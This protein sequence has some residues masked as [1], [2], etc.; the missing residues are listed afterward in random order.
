MKSF[1]IRAGVLALALLIPAATVSGQTAST[2]SV[3]SQQVLVDEY[4]A[5][6]HNDDLRAG[7]FSWTELDLAS[8]GTNA[9]QSEAV[10][11]KLKAGMMPPVGIPRPDAADARAFYRAL[12]LVVDSSAVD[13]PYAGAPELHR[14]NR[15]EYAN[16]VRELLDFDVDVS[17]LLPPDQMS[18]GFDN[19]ADSLSVTPALVQGYVRAASQISRRAVG[20]TEVAPTMSMY[21]VPKVFNQVRHIEGTP[22]GTRGGTSVVYNFPADGE[23]TFKVTFYH[24]FIT[25]LFGRNLPQNLQG[26]E[27]EI[28]IDGA[29]LAIFEI[30]PA[31]GE[32]EN[33]LTTER[34]SVTAGEH[35]I[36]AAFIKKFDGPTED[37]FRQVEQTM[38]DVTAAVPGLIG[39][40]HLHTLTIAGPFVVTGMSETP[41]RLRIFSCTPSSSAEELPCAEQIVSTLARHAYRRPITDD[42]VE[43]LI[44]HYRAGREEGDFED[45]IQMAVQAVLSHPEFVFR[46]EKV[47][48]NVRPGTNYRISDLELASRLAFFLWSSLPDDRLLR[49]ASEERLRDPAILEQEVGRMLADDRATA[50]ADN[51]AYQWLRLQTVKEADPESLVFP[52]FTRNLG[53]SMTRETKMLFESILREDRNITDLLTADYTFVDEIL[54]KHYGIPDVLGNRFRRVSLTDSNRFGLLGHGSVLTLTSL[55]NRTSP[56]MRGKY[57]MEV[58]I[59]SPPPPPPPVVPP[60]EEAVDNQVVRSVRERLEQHRENPACAA[61][62]QMMDPIGLTLENFDAI[63]QWRENDGG[64]LIDPS[65]RMYDGTELDGP[66]SLRQAMLDHSDAFIGTFTENLLQYGVGRVLD[67]RDM[68]TVR[69]IVG[70]ASGNGNRFS[71][72]VLGVVNSVPFQ[73]RRADDIPT[74]EQQ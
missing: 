38:V 47:P 40:P 62:H 5:G 57:V 58:L 23:Y 16:S 60:L 18:G 14:L 69:S 61:C 41:S 10:I 45:G 73:M 13:N 2:M 34:I 9:V 29:R 53:E 39:L 31:L 3:A 15:T 1:C 65:A 55:A 6:C 22:L 30:D 42:D 49:L 37:Q 71:E 4:C 64:F 52:N 68:P 46:F 25:E 74:A 11:R 24:D 8:P 26:Q 17:T 72:F 19:I 59:G 20:D 70:E 50:L 32:L 35:R 28:S 66:I 7:G 44:N 54:A 67:Y 36:A 21:T 33:V 63:G 12:E 51:F 27:I 56:V 43:F 48:A